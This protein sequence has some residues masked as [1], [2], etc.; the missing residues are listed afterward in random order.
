MQQTAISLLS[1]S[2][3]RQTRVLFAEDEEAAKL[4]MA[5]TLKRYFDTVDTAGDGKEGLE[6][7]IQN[8]Y[9]IV[10]TDLNMPKMDG[11]KML[12]GIRVQDSNAALII[13]TAYSDESRLLKAIDLGVEA[14]IKK[15]IQIQKLLSIIRKTMSDRIHASLLTQN[16]ILQAKTELL[17]DIAHHWRQPL[18]VISLNLT[19]IENRVKEK[20]AGDEEIDL[21]VEKAGKAIVSLSNLIDSF[22]DIYK[23]RAEQPFQVSEAV[24]HA[25]KIMEGYF[26]RENT[27][28]V[29]ESQCASSL[30]GDPGKLKQV[31]TALFKNAVDS[32]DKNSIRAIRITVE[33]S[34][35]DDTLR[36]S[37]QDNSGGIPEKYLPKI[38]DPYFTSKYKTSHAG[39]ELFLVKSII[40][41]HFMGQINVMNHEDG[42]RFVIEI[43]KS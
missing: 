29:I 30:N 10:I 14:F 32:A 13:T 28:L 16:T 40:E 18:N 24:A 34:I 5:R 1:D 31:F 38:F 25:D 43:P 33:E 21:L 17:M 7:F 4:L 12:E 39:L 6:K 15:P 27:Q 20:G 26:D 9:D 11:L 35:S 19:M 41:N 37:I 42:A 2:L 23:D 8:G 36:L 22:Y 3:I